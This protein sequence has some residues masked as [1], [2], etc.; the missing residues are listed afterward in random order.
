MHN[1]FIFPMD[2]TGT[3]TKWDRVVEIKEINGKKVLRGDGKS[4]NES[5]YNPFEFD[6]LI[7]QFIEF[8]EKVLNGGNI[9]K[10]I[11]KWLSQWGPLFW[12]YDNNTV[13]N[14]WAEA[15]KFYKLWSFYRLIANR[16]KE[17]LLSKI[18]IEKESKT[19]YKLTFFTEEPSFQPREWPM[20]EVNTLL[21][22]KLF[23][24]PD[25]DFKCIFPMKLDKNKNEFEQ[26]QEYSMLFLI[27][28]IEEYTK[29]AMLSWG[30][31]RHEKEDDKSN[32]KIEPVLYTESL[33]D[34]I[35]LQF[36]ILFSENKKKIC[37]VC[38]KPFIPDRKDQRYC[39]S[40]IPGKKSSCYLTA[41]S[42]RFRE[43]K[44]SN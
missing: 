8:T 12:E 19:N 36:Y 26:I 21:G 2:C 31:M 27:R 39:P 37:P 34:A 20:G 17:L 33:I 18:Q 11:K 15:T 1:T 7:P 43:K 10:L 24:E 40:I 6:N 23:W 14:F 41:K 30:S 35:Y 28:Q 9:E 44:T 22:K 32:F 29:R 42:R 13:E 4:F 16:E 5:R 38:N 25:Y 3:E